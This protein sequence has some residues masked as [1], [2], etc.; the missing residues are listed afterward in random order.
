MHRRSALNS[1]I[2][3]AQNIVSRGKA[4]PSISAKAKARISRHS[5]IMRQWIPLQRFLTLSAVLDD[6]DHVVETSVP[7][8][9]TALAEYW[10]PFLDGSGNNVSRPCIRTFLDG[11]SFSKWNWDNFSMPNVNQLCKC[12]NQ[13]TDSSPGK[14]GVPYSGLRHSH[15]H[16][17][18]LPLLLDD[19]MTKM[20]H[21]SPSRPLPPLCGFNDNV[22]SCIPK[23]ETLPFLNGVACRASGTRSLSC[24]NT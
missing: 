14:D 3:D 16:T 1:R 18:P 21:F 7:G 20:R 22:Q 4:S 23:K 11:M 19:A 12:I 13:V 2:N 5:D 8:V 6:N 9:I 10:R 24:K 15:L 17:S